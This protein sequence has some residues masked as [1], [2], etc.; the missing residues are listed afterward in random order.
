MK[1]RLFTD[2][3]VVTLRHVN[4]MQGLLSDHVYDLQ[5]ICAFLIY[6]PSEVWIAIIHYRGIMTI[7]VTTR[8]QILSFSRPTPLF[9]DTSECDFTGF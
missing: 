7:L 6:C 4:V 2:N 3:N 1:A 5:Y 9:S 8:F